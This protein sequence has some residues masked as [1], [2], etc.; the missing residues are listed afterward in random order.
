[1]FARGAYMGDDLP[2]DSHLL[3]FLQELCSNAVFSKEAVVSTTLLTIFVIL[4]LVVSLHLQFL[5]M[6]E[7]EDESLSSHTGWDMKLF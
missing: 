5:G 2:I 3:V 7:R 6:V 4:M 1:M